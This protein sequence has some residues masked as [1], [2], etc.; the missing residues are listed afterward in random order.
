MTPPRVTQQIFTRLVGGAK[1]T[2]VTELVERELRELRQD[3]ILVE[4]LYVSL[5]GSFWLASHPA[6]LHPRKEE[7]IESGGFVFGNS[8]VGRVV[9]SETPATGVGDYVTVF[10]H[11]PCGRDDCHACSVLH[12]YVECEFGKSTIIG[13][14]RGAHDGTYARHA[15]LPRYSYEVCYRAVERPDEA[16]LVP[17]M[18][19]FLLADVRNALTRHPETLKNHRMLLFGAGHAGHVA[20][21][22][23]LRSSPLARL[24]V[25]ESSPTRAASLKKLAPD[26]VEVYVPDKEIIERLNSGHARESEWHE[27]D[28]TIDGIVETMREHFG[29]RLCNVL[30]DASSGNTVPLWDNPRV[31]SPGCHCIPFGFGSDGL[32]LSRELIQVSGLTFLTSRGVGDLA[33]RREVIDVIRGD[34]SH[35]VR[36]YLKGA[37]RCL[38]NLDEAIAFI[39]EQ[40]ALPGMLHEVPHAYMTLNGI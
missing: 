12:R 20:A 23:H 29:G 18:Y 3:E 37:S 25:V 34:G 24:V 2:L 30:F 8:G 11:A 31:L 40:H 33:N 9:A 13:H 16:A 39:G 22:I 4:M 35:F 7:F 14:G 19:A 5:H 32:V 1:P 27:R 17:F 15:I 6:L 10:G 26:A 21:Y 38:G 28:E 36:H